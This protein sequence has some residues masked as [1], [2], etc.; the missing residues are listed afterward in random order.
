[1]PQNAVIA[2]SGGDY[3]TLIA[4]E[5]GEQNSD[6]GA[7]TVGRVNGF[8]DQGG[9]L[10]AINGAWVNGA[11]LEPFDSA[12]GFDGTER[13]LCGVTSSNSTATIRLRATA[14]CEIEGLEVY[15]TSTSSAATAVTSDVGE[16]RDVSFCLFKSL[17]RLTGN[18][19]T[20]VGI[21]DS[22]LVVDAATTTNG[23]SGVTILNRCSIFYN[24]TRETGAGTVS[25][26]FSVN[27]GTG[28]D[29]ESTLT[30][31]N[32]AS[33]DTSA[34]AINNIVIADNFESSDPVG[35][36]DY[37]IKSG[38]ILDTNT[39]GA[40]IQGGGGGIT[41][42][43]ATANYNYSAITGEIDLTGEIIVTGGTANY[44]YDGIVGSIDLTGEIV[45]TGQ[46]A[47]YNYSAIDGSIELTGA[48]TVIGQTANYD[49]DGIAADIILQGSIIV[50]GSTANYDYNALNGTIIIQ[51]PIT[52]NPKNIIRV[53]RKSNTVRVSRKSNTIRVKRNSNIVRVR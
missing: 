48:I 8:F 21:R 6:Y 28:D 45:I 20:G 1:M 49:Y 43:G 10:L 9:S 46:T 53:S 16:P 5:A 50:T 44:D 23:F 13:Q 37:R 4:W 47:N 31:S 18:F 51:G 32:N 12:D 15:N 38:S 42:T 14:I 25:N 19:N 17:G 26:S 52:L 27:I 41:I 7:I 11:R 24:S 3:T 22:V 35:D 36:G 39:I 2:A 30:Q 40:F 33:T 29:W 34:D